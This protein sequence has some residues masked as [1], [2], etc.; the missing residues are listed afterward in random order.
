LKHRFA[1]DH[2]C[3]GFENTGRAMNLAG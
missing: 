1:E 3:Q 2:K